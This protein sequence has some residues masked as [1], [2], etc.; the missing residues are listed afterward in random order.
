[1]TIPSQ[2]GYL[3]PQYLSFGFGF[4]LSHLW[5]TAT[6]SYYYYSWFVNEVYGVIFNFVC[7]K[8]SSPCTVDTE[9]GD[10]V[11]PRLC[12]GISLL[13]DCSIQTKPRLPPWC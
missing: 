4:L 1:M 3:G 5:W 2:T 12:A 6:L 13:E 11:C 8:Y 7:V 9:L 10:V